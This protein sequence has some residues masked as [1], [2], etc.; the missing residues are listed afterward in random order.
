[1]EKMDR[2]ALHAAA[3]ALAPLA[4]VQLLEQL[5]SLPAEGN[6]SVPGRD[7]LGGGAD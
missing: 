7:R 3:E 2:P 1:M 5:K 4:D 6:V